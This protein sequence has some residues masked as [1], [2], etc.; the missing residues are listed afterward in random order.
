MKKLLDLRF[1]I[2]AFFSAVGLLLFIYHFTGGKNIAV[3]SPVNLI[4]GIVFMVFGIFMIVL[5]SVSK[6]SED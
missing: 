5:S 1:V 6:I 2:G 3:D 4:T